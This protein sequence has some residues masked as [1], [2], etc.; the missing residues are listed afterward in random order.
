MKFRALTVHILVIS[1][2]RLMK[3][4][5]TASILSLWLASLQIN[6][7]NKTQHRP[8]KTAQKALS[9]KRNR[10]KSAK[11]E[12]LLRQRKLKA[13]TRLGTVHPNKEASLMLKPKKV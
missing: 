3:R 6:L 11:M 1:A 9:T 5:A 13:C 8:H 10:Q 7:G 12:L 2:L 4:Y